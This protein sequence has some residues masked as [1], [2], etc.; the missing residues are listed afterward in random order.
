MERSKPQ[1]RSENHMSRKTTALRARKVTTLEPTK[2]KVMDTETKKIVQYV[3]TTI[4]LSRGRNYRCWWCTLLI[5]D[6]P[7]GCPI[8]VLHDQDKKTYSTDG[9]F[10]SF[11][12]VKAYINDKEKLDVTYKNSHVLLGHMVCDMNGSIAPVSVKPSPDKRLLIEYGG[13]MTED[14]YKHCFDRMLYTEKGVIKMY[15]VTLIFQEEEKI[16]NRG[17]PSKHSPHHRKTSS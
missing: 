15:P 14:Q 10:C 4:N 13:Y 16:G 1:K 8:N 9:V 7:I 3:S 5:E 2:D 17:T 6:E 11:N 12:C